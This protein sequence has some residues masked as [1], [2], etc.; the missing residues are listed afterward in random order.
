[1]NKFQN[2]IFFSCLFSYIFSITVSKIEPSSVTFGEDATFILTVQDYDSSDNYFYLKNANDEDYIILDCSP[3]INTYDKLSCSA[4]I[5]IYYKEELN[6]LIKTLYVNDIRT[7]LTV[8]LEKPKT[9]KLLNFNDDDE[10][11]SYEI[12]YLEFKV[13]YN[14]LYN[15]DVSIKLGD[16]S[17]TNCK[18]EDGSIRKIICYYEFPESST[19]KSLNLIFDKKV[20]EYSINIEAPPYEFSVISRLYRDTYYF[21]SST[22]EVYFEVDS[23]YKM[24]DHSI[25]LV[26]ENSDNENIILSNCTY[27]SYG[28]EYGKCSGILNKNDAYYVYYDGKKINAKLFVY[29]EQTAITKVQ[30]IRPYK[31]L[32]S[33]S[34]NTFTLDVDYIVNLDKAVFTLVDKFNN[35][36]KIDLTKCSKVENSLDQI[37]CEGTINNAV[38]YY[39]YLNGVKQD[40]NIRGYSL[41]LSKA[42][43]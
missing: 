27:Y 18:L 8:T 38:N 30:K 20:T 15:S 17:I 1:M 11:Y 29:P 16:L 5:K 22:Q 3:L 12:S 40:E 33:S 19:G 37:T 26:P 43:Y 10:F 25:Y 32:I 23:S 42:L 2:L 41:S 14:E 31:L 4:D 24:N 13:N 35:D 34:P 39:V 21:S 28:L 6:F 9:L 7:K 36:N